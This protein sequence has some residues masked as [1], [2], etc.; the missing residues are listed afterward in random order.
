MGTWG[1]VGVETVNADPD[2]IK[3]TITKSR[4]QDPKDLAS[5]AV[6]VNSKY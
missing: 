6:L 1:R 4:L 5:Y 2:N 3:Y